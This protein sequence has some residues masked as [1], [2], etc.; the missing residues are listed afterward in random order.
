MSIFFCRWNVSGGSINN[1]EE[2]YAGL[3]VK[4][5]PYTNLAGMCQNYVSVWGYSWFVVLFF[6]NLKI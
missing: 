3:R 5:L 4:S 1:G 2:E 6:F